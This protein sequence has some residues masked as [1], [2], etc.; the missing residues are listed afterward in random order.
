MHQTQTI[1]ACREYQL[2]LTGVP[3]PSNKDCVVTLA[4]M[5]GHLSAEE[6][7]DSPMRIKGK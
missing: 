3:W 4:D 2:C 6:K 1:L 5:I 7:I